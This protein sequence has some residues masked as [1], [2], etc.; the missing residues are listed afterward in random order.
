[1]SHYESSRFSNVDKRVFPA[2]L[3]QVVD[4]GAFSRV[5]AISGFEAC[6]IFPLNPL[7]ITDEK[8]ATSAPLTE[9]DKGN[10]QSSDTLPSTSSPSAS[11]SP[12]STS[13]Q[14]V[15]TI[16]PR[17]GIERAILDHLRRTTPTSTGQVE[18]RTRVKR[19]FAE[20]L[21]SAEAI[22]RINNTEKQKVKTNVDSGS[23]VRKSKTG[24]QQ[25]INVARKTGKG[26]NRPSAV[27]REQKVNVRKPIWLEN[28]SSVSSGQPEHQSDVPADK[29]IQIS[30]SSNVS[31][32][33]RPSCSYSQDSVQSVAAT[34]PL[35]SSQAM[36]VGTFYKKRDARAPLRYSD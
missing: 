10:E 2:I 7:K 25:K 3:K 28:K 19:T 9:L 20:S 21:T 32:D 13:E 31:E 15:A 8:L 1:M 29:D 5:N 14:Q 33:N 36:S 18:K 35:I 6:G 34:C 12:E 17:K 4:A 16:T 23:K 24:V 22:E 30:C 27:P 26:S 11:A